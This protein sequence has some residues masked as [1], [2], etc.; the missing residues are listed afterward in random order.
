MCKSRLNVSRLLRLEVFQSLSVVIDTYLL[1]L[2]E[3]SFVV[4]FFVI[5]LVVVDLNLDVWPLDALDAARSRGV[6]EGLEPS[7]VDVDDV[8]IG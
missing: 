3:D 2:V 7:A 5:L 8:D 1:N 4:D 6:L